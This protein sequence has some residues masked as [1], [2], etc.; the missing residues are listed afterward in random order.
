M[1]IDL[2]LLT[3]QQTIYRIHISVKFSQ[4]STGKMIYCELI[5]PLISIYIEN[6]IFT[7]FAHFSSYFIVD[8]IRIEVQS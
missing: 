8:R 1:I 7:L 5:S 2:E 3:D 6:D 4:L